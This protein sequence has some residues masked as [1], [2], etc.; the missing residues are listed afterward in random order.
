MK[1]LITAGP[2]REFLDD[3]RFLSN[4]SSGKTGYAL[5]H[6]FASSGDEVVLIS[7]AT[8]LEAPSG[9]AFVRVQSALEMQAALV[10]KF[11]WCECLIMAAAVCDYRPAEKIAGKEKKAGVDKLLKLVPNPDILLEA[12][13][14]KLDRILV[15]F[16]LETDNLIASASAKLKRK[17]LDYIVANS[18]AT[19]GSD[20]IT[21][22]ILSKE[23][24]LLDLTDVSKEDFSK[25]LAGI[26]RTKGAA[27]PG[28]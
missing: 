6:F 24:P 10:S 9:C 15:G 17:N 28:A 25:R 8:C 11:D 1:I 16:S 18:P 2:T 21:C 7:G 12:G 22:T 19:F 3:V 5:A 4:A 23:G 20:R 14:R 26:I 13:R 27:A